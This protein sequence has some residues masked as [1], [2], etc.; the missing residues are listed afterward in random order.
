MPDNINGAIEEENRR[1]VVANGEA[2]DV[3][4]APGAENTTVRKTENANIGN[5]P[6]TRNYK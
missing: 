5:T 1:E 3:E 4:E 2:M 6:R